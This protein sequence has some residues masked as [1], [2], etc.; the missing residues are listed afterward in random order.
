MTYAS[1]PDRKRRFS[2]RLDIKAMLDP[3]GDHTGL[4]SSQSPSV[5]C[6]VSMV[7]TLAEKM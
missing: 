4:V 2:N 1:V 5:S 3:S 7:A 6:C